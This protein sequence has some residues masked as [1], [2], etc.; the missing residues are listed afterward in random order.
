MHLSAITNP[1]GVMSASDIT[2]KEKVM[3]PSDITTRLLKRVKGW[4]FNPH[5]LQIK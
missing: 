5:N 3:S 1:K 4:G 2:T